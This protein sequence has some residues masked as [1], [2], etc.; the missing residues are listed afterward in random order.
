MKVTAL[1][2]MCSLICDCHHSTPEWTESGVLVIRTNNVRNG[3][4]DLQAPS[5]TTEET[6]IERTKRAVPTSGDLMI[7]REAPMGEVCLIPQGITCCL[8]QRMVL[9][10]PDGQK[11]FGGYL[12]YAL[13]SP[14]RTALD[15][16]KRGLMQRLLTGKLRV[17]TTQTTT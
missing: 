11:A 6:Y 16:Q 3:R 4:L 1:E 12:L 14:L 15:Q 8:G 2:A 10:R 5:Y 17:K 9:L 7:T 13:Q